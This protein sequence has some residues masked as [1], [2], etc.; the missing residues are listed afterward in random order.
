MANVYHCKACGKESVAS[1]CNSC[2]LDELLSQTEGG[3]DDLSEILK[4][5]TK[6]YGRLKNLRD[7]RI[8]K[9]IFGPKRIR[10]VITDEHGNRCHLVNTYGGWV[11]V[12]HTGQDETTERQLDE[13]ELEPVAG[14]Q[15][16]QTQ[17]LTKIK[18]ES[19]DGPRVITYYE[20]DVP[21]HEVRKPTA[22]IF[23]KVTPHRS[24]TYKSKP[25]STH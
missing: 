23:P 25:P 24:K 16:L 19:V 9:S 7:L 13:S 5:L 17:K 20:G 14:G 12:A 8:Y 15:V 11:A 10:R 3:E 22:M 2:F 6:K 18:G 1:L 4:N 21:I